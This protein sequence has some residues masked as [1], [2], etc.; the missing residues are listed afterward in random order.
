MAE[1]LRTH[2]ALPSVTLDPNCAPALGNRTRAS[3]MIGCGSTA[4]L[5]GY[6]TRPDTGPPLDGL[7]GL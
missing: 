1:C 7:A 3:C 5:S 4:W 2:T 6:R